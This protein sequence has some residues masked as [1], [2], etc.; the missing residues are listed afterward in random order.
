MLRILLSILLV[1]FAVA[2]YSAHAAGLPATMAIRKVGTTNI[3]ATYG[4]GTPTLLSGLVGVSNFV[5]YN[6]SS[7]AI[8]ISTRGATCSSTSPD[9]YYIPTST[10]LRVDNVAI[11]K[12]ICV[13]GVDSAGNGASVSAGVVF[14][15]A[16]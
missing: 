13:R 15:S 8:A 2:S 10:G 3:P 1:T 6:G 16:W 14:G 4:A 11:N 5:I 7:S 12:V 9:S